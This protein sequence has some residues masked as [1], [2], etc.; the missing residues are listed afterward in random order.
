VNDP[1][2]SLFWISLLFLIVGFINWI[3]TVVL[4]LTKIPKKQLITTGPY[5]IVKHPLYA[6]VALLV[7]PWAGFMLHTWLG[8]VLGIV[9][10]VGSRIFSPEE[11][12]LLSRI[13]GMEWE[14]YN[15][16][17]MLPWI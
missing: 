9:V 17:V 13:F 8:V 2:G 15:K 5:A 14:E 1:S 7:L 10:Y 6:G 3:W 11:E 4:I 16:K 12:K